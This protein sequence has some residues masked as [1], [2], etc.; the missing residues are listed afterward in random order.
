[1]DHRHVTIS[2]R[3]RKKK[4]TRRR[5]LDAAMELFRE[6][7][8]SATTVE[9]ITEHADVAK[10]TFFN[11]FPSKEALLSELSVWGV[12][13][14]REAIDVSNGGPKSAVARIKLL[15]RLEEQVREGE[16]L[17]RGAF[18]ARLFHPP[19]PE[20]ARRRLSG[21]LTELVSEAQAQGEIRADLDTGQV[22]NLL[23]M[24]FFWNIVTCCGDESA[25]AAQTSIE[26]TIDLWLD[27]IAGPNWSKEWD[28]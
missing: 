6:Q 4:E 22:S 2:R 25:P 7:G 5:L 23:H 27:G 20:N 28:H 17:P 11:Y 9:D 18:A 26:D 24:T 13:K 8:Y 12:E 10:G 16:R 21:I 14:L 19:T 1:M 15:M 3:E